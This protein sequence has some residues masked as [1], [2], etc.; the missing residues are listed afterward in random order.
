MFGAKF[1]VFSLPFGLGVG[2]QPAL[3]FGPKLFLLFKVRFAAPRRNNDEDGRGA[4]IP[5]HV[6]V[7]GRLQIF[8]VAFDDVGDDR[9]V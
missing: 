4:A 1:I 9:R 2:N 5:L 7:D 6:P 3:L 8:V